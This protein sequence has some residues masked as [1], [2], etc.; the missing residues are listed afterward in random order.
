[1]DKVVPLFDDEHQKVQML[2]PWRLTGRLDAAD[3]A[4]VSR[5]LEVCRDCRAELAA[6]QLLRREFVELPFAG[7]EA[8]AKMG[9]AVR[10]EKRKARPAAWVAR[11]IDRLR[12]GFSPGWAP[13]VM[14]GQ[15]V[16]LVIVGAVALRPALTPAPA[17][18][19]Y[20]AL[21]AAPSAHAANL[22][23]ILKPETSTGQMRADLAA[24]GGRVV[25]GP[26]EAS[27]FLVEVKGAGRDA[28]LKYL[29][30]RPEVV[31]AEAIDAG[32]RP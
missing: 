15:A 4:L 17:S 2:L 7:D 1:M 11:L 26:S 18:P 8:W 23:L 14:A 12:E 5:H 3:D 19:Q 31:M 29:K 20:A 22:A 13:L 21:G 25:D 9:E 27:V 28:A 32:A 24:I 6:E 30:G 10:A 16:V